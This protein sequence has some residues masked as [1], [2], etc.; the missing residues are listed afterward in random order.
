MM[1]SGSVKSYA[2]FIWGA[3]LAGLVGCVPG[4]GNG[5]AG[6]GAGAGKL[7]ASV[8]DGA[9]NAEIS[10]AEL[11]AETTFEVNI[12]G[13]APGAVIDIVING[14]I[15]ATV[16]LD[17]NGNVHAQYSSLPDD[18]SGELPLPDDFP[19]LHAGDEVGVGQGQGMFSEDDS[20]D[21]ND[22]GDD[23]GDSDDDA[24]FELRAEMS[25]ATFRAEVSYEAGVDRTEFEVEVRGG[26]PGASLEVTIRGQ[27]VTTVTLDALGA[28]EVKFRDPPGDSGA[29]P[30]PADFPVPQAGDAVAVG[31]LTGTFILDDD[32]GN[33]GDDDDGDNGNDNDNDNGADDDNANDNEDNENDNAG[34]GGTG[35]VAAGQTL[36]ADHCAVCHGPEGQGGL[37]ESIQGESAG[38]IR[39]A[40]GLPE[41][42]GVAALNLSD[43]DLLDLEAYLNSF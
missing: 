32:G 28:G 25:D 42:A 18:S 26:Q 31:A 24:S 2:P 29:P 5:G 34:G 27:L 33:D 38:D 1:S 36:V 40:L 13:G 8:V 43:Q 9:L 4:A 22:N 6:D 11:A 10:F 19:N 3:L 35:D 17:E 30:F 14:Q 7:T 12:T 41:M 16:T 20:E 37:F 21:D 23:D 15:A 39:E